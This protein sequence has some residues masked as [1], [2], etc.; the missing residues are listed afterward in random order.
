MK[1][2]SIMCFYSFNFI[3]MAQYIEPIC[4]WRNKKGHQPDLQGRGW[5][6]ELE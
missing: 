5:L 2:L 6:V 1:Q 4:M 3:N